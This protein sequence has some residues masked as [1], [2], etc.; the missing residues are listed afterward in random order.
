[1]EDILHDPNYQDATACFVVSIQPPK[2]E[3]VRFNASIDP[4]LLALIDS[5]AK[6]MG[7]TRSG[8]LAEAARKELNRKGTLSTQTR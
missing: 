4:E 2:R 3:P 7:M 6:H 1:L 5:H 8:F